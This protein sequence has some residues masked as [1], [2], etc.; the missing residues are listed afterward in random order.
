MGDAPATPAPAKAVALY[1][2]NADDEDELTFEED[3][4]ITVTEI[5]DEYNWATGTL[6]GRTG[7]FPRTYIEFQKP[8]PAVAPPPAQ[9]KAEAEAKATAGAGGAKKAEAKAGKIMSDRL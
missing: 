6:D 5:D 7:Q 9:R 1:D 3:D 4:V 8:P 2:H